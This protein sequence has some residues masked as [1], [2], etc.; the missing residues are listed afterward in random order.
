MRAAKVQAILRIPA[1][2]SEPSLLAHTSSESRGTFRQKTRSLAPLNG[3]AC[4]VEICHDGMLEDTNSLD[5][6]HII[7][8]YLSSDFHRSTATTIVTANL[9]FLLTI[10]LSRC[11]HVYLH[12]WVPAMGPT[13][14]AISHSETTIGQGACLLQLARWM[15]QYDWRW[16]LISF[17]TYKSSAGMQ[18]TPLTP[19]LDPLNHV[20][21]KSPLGHGW[22]KEAWLDLKGGIMYASMV[23]SVVFRRIPS[24]FGAASLSNATEW[25]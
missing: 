2:S 10:I 9:L 1:V 12:G 6:A 14:P 3:W 24:N 19:S 15:L 21:T 7:L 16:H 11:K 17:S 8:V 23:P 4:A 13:R 25:T 18:L 22:I 5:A 20:I